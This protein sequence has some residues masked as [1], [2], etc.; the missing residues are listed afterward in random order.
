MQLF[1]QLGIR[2][3]FLTVIVRTVTFRTCYTAYWAFQIRHYFF[4]SLATAKIRYGARP[5]YPQLVL[6]DVSVFVGQSPVP[7]F[8][9]FPSTLS[10]EGPPTATKTSAPARGRA[11]WSF[12]IL[13][14]GFVPPPSN[15]FS[16]A[17]R[18]CTGPLYIQ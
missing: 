7:I 16:S 18:F 15:S 10:G 1:W 9:F 6:K 4:L 5:E 3:P 11:A 14:P 12:L 17:L 2:E 8:S 13:G